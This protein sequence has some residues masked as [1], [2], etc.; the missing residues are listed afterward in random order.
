MLFTSNETLQDLRHHGTLGARQRIVLDLIRAY[1]GSS[2]RELAWRGSYADPNT[3]RPR[4]V[5]LRAMGYIE[6]A[7]VRHCMVSGQTVMTWRLKT[8][9]PQGEL[10]L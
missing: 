7:G 1:P 4:L 6:E 5:E 3:V 10:G 8:Y 9:E 2:A